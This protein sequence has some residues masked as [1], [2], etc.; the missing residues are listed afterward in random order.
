MLTL[1]SATRVYLAAGATDLR[2]GF[3]GLAALAAGVVEGDS[4]S[5]HVF[6]FCN[7]T[8]TRL[9]ALF[10]DGTGLWVCAKRLE[11]GRFSWP[12]LGESALGSLPRRVEV[13]REEF[14]LLVGGMEMER[15]VRKRWW[16]TDSSD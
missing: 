5:G 12:G 8:R 3:D 1:G 9:K 11:G 10:W 13:S 15:V 2:K 16:G 7:R 14:A 6:V 4:L